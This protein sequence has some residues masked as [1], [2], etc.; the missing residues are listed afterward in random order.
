MGIANSF[1]QGGIFGFAG[2]FPPKYTGAVM[3]GNGFSGL[4]MNIFR[5][6]TLA[7]FPPKE[8]DDDGNHDNTAF[9]GCLIYFAIASLI[10]VMCIFG[11]FYVCKT[12]FAQY[13]M[14][15]AGDENARS[16][17]LNIAA[18]SAGSL[19]HADNVALFNGGDDGYKELDN[20]INNTYE[21][22]SDKTFFDVYKDVSFMATQVFV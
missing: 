5:M 8:V 21:E 3:F 16:M 20:D 19:G 6:C 18:R 22:G 7:A 9:I 12:E 15:Q 1:A 10:I 17:S 2:I 11:Y 13:Y 4:A 14:K